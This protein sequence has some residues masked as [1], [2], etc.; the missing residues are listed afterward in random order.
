[1]LCFCFCLGW[2]GGGGVQGSGLREFAGFNRVYNPIGFTG[3]VGRLGFGGVI[4]FF[5]V[6]TGFYRVL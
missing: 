5:K 1:M 4:G 2:G 6:F 3:F